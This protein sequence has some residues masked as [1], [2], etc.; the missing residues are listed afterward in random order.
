[1]ET[2]WMFV[3]GCTLLGFIAP[4]FMAVFKLRAPLGLNLLSAAAA[5]LVAAAFV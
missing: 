1:M 3:A 2:P 5:G 4:E